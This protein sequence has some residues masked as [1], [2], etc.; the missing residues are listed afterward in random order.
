[1]TGFSNRVLGMH[2]QLPSRLLLNGKF[3]TKRNGGGLY[4]W[5]HLLYNTNIKE[6]K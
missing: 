1:M 5:L 2:H 4:F 6:G 3:G